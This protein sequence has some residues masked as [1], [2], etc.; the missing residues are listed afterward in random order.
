MIAWMPGLNGAHCAQAWLALMCTLKGTQLCDPLHYTPACHPMNNN[1]S[2]TTAALLAC[3]ALA[4]CVSGPSINR[5]FSAPEAVGAPYEN[6]LVVSLFNSMETRKILER[7]TIKQLKARGVNA[8]SLAAMQKPGSPLNRDGMI[9]AAEEMSADAVLVTQLVSYET[10]VK[11]KF[12]SPKAGYK[13]GATYYY[14]VYPVALTEYVEPPTVLITEDVAL[15]TDLYSAQSRSRVWAVGSETRI[16]LDIENMWDDSA[17][18]AD[19][20][21]GVNNLARDSL[22]RR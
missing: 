15:Q 5:I 12:R 16:K 1:L 19:A 6:I 22:I 3:V 21:A 8:A 14:D 17:F 18:T 13:Y 11:E 20:T 7:E 9:S 10:S 2:R 4:A